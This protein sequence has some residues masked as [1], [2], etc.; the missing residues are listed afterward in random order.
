[1]DSAASEWQLGCPE[2]V[3]IGKSFLCD[4][5]IVI[6]LTYDSVNMYASTWICTKETSIEGSP[7]T[8][9]RARKASLA[10]MM[11]EGPAMRME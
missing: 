5:G 3:L 10:E 11:L 7:R 1:V 6:M 8:S 9:P 4:S 2:V